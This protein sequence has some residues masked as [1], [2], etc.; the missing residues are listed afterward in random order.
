MSTD[1]VAI[2]LCGSFI[3]LERIEVADLGCPRL[4]VRPN[5]PEHHCPSPSQRL[6]SRSK[7]AFQSLEWQ[8]MRWNLEQ[9]TLGQHIL[10][11]IGFMDGFAQ[12]LKPFEF[13]QLEWMVRGSRL[14]AKLEQ[15]GLWSDAR[16]TIPTGLGQSG[17]SNQFSSRITSGPT[18]VGQKGERIAAFVAAVTGVAEGMKHLAHSPAHKAARGAI[19]EVLAE[20][21]RRPL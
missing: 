18:Q 12:V 17:T 3:T 16:V 11:R 10:N 9:S 20:S 1:Q 14:L 5:H 6:T 19:G 13:S 4:T 21:L 15:A 7:I 2:A 8:D